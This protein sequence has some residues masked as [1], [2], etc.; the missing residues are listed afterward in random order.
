MN[1]QSEAVSSRVADPACLFCRI[2]AGEIPAARVHE[3]DVVIAIRDIAPRAPTHV[4]F[5]PRE[6][7]ASA[8]ELTPADGP[9]LGR[10]FGAAAAFARAEGLTDA[11]Y[12][13]V[14]NVGEWGG[15]TVGHLH[16]HL[17][18]GRSMTW[19]PG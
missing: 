1:D 13:M 7:I 11:G 8:A 6:H 16:V 2:V 3:D 12:R 4:L 19:P 15:Q 14:T 5:L 18:G 17:L 10:L 9:M